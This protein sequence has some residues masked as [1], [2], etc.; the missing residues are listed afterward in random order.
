[1]VVKG[2]TSSIHLVEVS[3]CVFMVTSPGKAELGARNS[4]DVVK[5]VPS[6]VDQLQDLLLEQ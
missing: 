5:F 1:M 4:L 6:M 2:N 3:L